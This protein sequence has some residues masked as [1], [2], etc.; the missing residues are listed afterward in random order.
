MSAS[1]HF[2]IFHD[3]L[4]AISFFFRKKNRLIQRK[5]TNTPPDHF[6]RKRNLNQPLSFTDSAL[7]CNFQGHQGPNVINKNAQLR[8]IKN[9]NPGF[10]ASSSSVQIQIET[11]LDADED[12]AAKP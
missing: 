7:Q 10:Y 6:I 5:C 3:D 4:Y 2:P 9:L 12:A 11:T 1:N 8:I